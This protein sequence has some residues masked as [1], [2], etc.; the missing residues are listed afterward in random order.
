MD[1]VAESPNKSRF[2][3]QKDYYAG[4]KKKGM[5]RHALI[6]DEVS[7]DIFVGLAERYSCTQGE[8]LQGMVSLAVNDSHISDGLAKTI[9][10]KPTITITAEVKAKRKE[11]AS[12]LKK[13]TPEQLDAVLAAAAA[14]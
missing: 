7:R 3:A 9:V 1:K 11:V 12:A 14:R 8:L 13:L 4:L 5:I 6:V 10:R 2:A